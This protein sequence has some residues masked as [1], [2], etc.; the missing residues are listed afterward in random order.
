MAT[1]L[2][3]PSLDEVF[4]SF[5]ETQSGHVT[6]TVLSQ[7]E[8]V[9]S[10]FRQFLEQDGPPLL[11]EPLAPRWEDAK[12]AGQRFTQAIQAPHLLRFVPPFMQD[13]EYQKSLLPAGTQ[14]NAEKVFHLLGRTLLLQELATERDYVLAVEAFPHYAPQLEP[15][16]LL[17]SLLFDHAQEDPP[18]G[19]V[20]ETVKGW[21]EIA[22]VQRGSLLLAPLIQQQLSPALKVPAEASALARTGWWI[23][24]HLLQTSHGWSLADVGSVLP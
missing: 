11:P 17:S 9:I 19:K 23:D 6:R 18:N 20:F 24:A 10:L 15:A 16:E 2:F 7:F 21:V 1:P 4:S 14:T 3:R 13:L 8:E 5:L 22:R 12:K